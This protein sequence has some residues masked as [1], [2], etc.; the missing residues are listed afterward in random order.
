[1]DLSEELE[2]LLEADE[3]EVEFGGVRLSAGGFLA[4]SWGVGVGVEVEVVTGLTLSKKFM[5]LRSGKRTWSLIS[6]IL[7]LWLLGCCFLVCFCTSHFQL[8]AYMQ[9]EQR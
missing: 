2:L 7:A 1:M 9:A 5:S 3:V 4:D 6:M 8:E